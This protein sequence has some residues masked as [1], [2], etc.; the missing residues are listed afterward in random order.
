ML[1][2]S[3]SSFDTWFPTQFDFAKEKIANEGKKPKEFFFI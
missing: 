2:L 1:F 3:S